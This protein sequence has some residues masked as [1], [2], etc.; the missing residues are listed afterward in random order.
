[1]VQ[2]AGPREAERRRKAANEAKIAYRGNVKMR[3]GEWV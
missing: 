1:M 2:E 3:K